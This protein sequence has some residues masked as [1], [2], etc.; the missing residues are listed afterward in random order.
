MNWCVSFCVCSSGVEQQPSQLQVLEADSNS[1]WP[2]ASSPTELNCTSAAAGDAMSTCIVIDDPEE[3]VD[4]S[5]VG[6]SPGYVHNN[7][8]SNESVQ[9]ASPCDSLEF[10]SGTLDCY[11]SPY[12]DSLSHDVWLND[13]VIDWKSPSP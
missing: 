11:Q 13:A 6:N 9:I 10:A 7:V 3:P 4:S 1:A 8:C 2:I 5:S 12:S